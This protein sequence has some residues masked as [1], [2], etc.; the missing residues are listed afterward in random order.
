MNFV[1]SN[2]N[3]KLPLLYSTFFVIVSIIFIIIFCQVGLGIVFGINRAL[4]CGHEMAVKHL[5]E[6][7][8]ELIEVGIFK[9]A[10]QVEPGVWTGDIDTCR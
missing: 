1:I 7:A 4:N 6:L 5:D 10:K 9:D 8:M 2:L 3:C